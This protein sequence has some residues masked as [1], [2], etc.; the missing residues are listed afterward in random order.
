MT[1][2]LIAGFLSGAVLIIAI[3]AQNSFV[4]RQGIRREHVLPIVVVCAGA[5]ALLIAAGIA[6]LG[7]LIDSAPVVINVAR[8]GGAAFLFGYGI[9]AARRAMQPH[10]LLVDSGIGSSLGAAMATC[11]AFTFLN[12]HVYLDT[13]ILLGSLANQR[14]GDGRWIFWGGAATAS[15]AWFFALGY[16]AR[17]LG[18]LF[19]K[20][21]AWRMLDSLISTI[22][23]GLGLTLLVG[24]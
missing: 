17:L 6:G 21:V 2:D 5:D 14:E 4:L 16:G 19:S 15:F 11:L 20:P 8:Y 7:V 23:V 12:P 24:R 13:V 9:V 1:A 18:P 10:Q 3:G 22:M